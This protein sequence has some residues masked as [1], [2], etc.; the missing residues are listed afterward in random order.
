M[1]GTGG[2][3]SNSSEGG[4]SSSAGS[5]EPSSDAGAGGERPASQD[6]A[7]IMAEYRAYEPQTEQP[8]PVSA[9]IFGLCRLPTLPEQAFAESKH[10]DGRYLQD[11]AN[12]LAVAGIARR[13]EPA[14]APG[15]V[16]VKEKYVPGATSGQF[17]LAALGFMIKRDP[18]FAPAHRDWEFAYWEP[19]LGIVSTPEQS[20]YCAGC[21][22]GAAETDSVFVDGLVP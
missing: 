2:S 4:D 9:Y 18:G 21:H 6:V 11:W 10:G 17:K 5:G 7:A 8:E 20:T 12:E 3:S 1:P 14:F 15:A 13:G 22:S 19:E 16:I